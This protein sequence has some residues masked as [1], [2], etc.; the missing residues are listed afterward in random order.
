MAHT[1]RKEVQAY[2]SA[3]ERLLS[4]GWDPDLTQDEKDL[5]AYYAQEMNVE[6]KEPTYAQA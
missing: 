5:V 2:V 4:R 3:C 1:I 6:F